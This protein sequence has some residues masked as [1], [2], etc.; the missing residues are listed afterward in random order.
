[1]AKLVE[2]KPPTQPTYVFEFTA[3]EITALNGFLG[4]LVDENRKVIIDYSIDES[5]VKPTPMCLGHLKSVYSVL[6][7]YDR[8]NGGY[9]YFDWWEELDA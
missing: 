1:M 3:D 8:D 4:D 5:R 9:D 6:E 2:V 7:P